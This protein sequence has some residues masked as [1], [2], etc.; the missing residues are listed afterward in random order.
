MTTYLQRKRVD[1]AATPAIQR[2]DAPVNAIA[3]GGLA[4]RTR[5]MRTIHRVLWRDARTPHGGALVRAFDTW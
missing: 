4:Q 1:V 3:V 2:P 5:A